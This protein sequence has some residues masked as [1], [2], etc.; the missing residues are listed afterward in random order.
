MGRNV[1]VTA[2]WDPE[3]CVWVATSDD[4][5]LVTEAPSMDALMAKLPG[6]LQDLLE[7]V[8]DG[9]EM[10]IPFEVIGHIHDSVRVRSR[11]A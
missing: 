10:E 4:I 5:P 11:A 3:V 2:T 1:V 8:D 7:D 6:L 9:E